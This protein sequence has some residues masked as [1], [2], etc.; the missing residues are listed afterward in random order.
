MH[1]RP[2]RSSRLAEKPR[3]EY[4]DYLQYPD[5]PPHTTF[6]NAIALLNKEAFLAS[7]YAEIDDIIVWSLF[8]SKRRPAGPGALKLSAVSSQNKPA[9]THEQALEIQSHCR[10]IP[11]TDPTREDCAG[12]ARTLSENF[13]RLFPAGQ[14]P[15]I[16]Q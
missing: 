11:S 3:V 1:R 12:T 7:P 8:S 15:I 10:M 13:P 9:I 16:A 2:R 6:E 4:K 5:G 14:V